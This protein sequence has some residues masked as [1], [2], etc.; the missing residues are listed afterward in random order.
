[1]FSSAEWE[2]LLIF[3]AVERQVSN[4]ELHNAL[5]VSKRYYFF[6]RQIFEKDRADSSVIPNKYA[7][8]LAF[9]AANDTSWLQGL[10]PT[11]LVFVVTS[12]LP[13]RPQRLPDNHQRIRALRSGKSEMTEF[14]ISA[15]L[16]TA[17]FR[18]VPAAVYVDIHI[19]DEVLWFRDK[20][21]GR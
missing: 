15:R 20:S 10:S 8:A 12:R 9:N 6:L 18:R 3:H 11:L 7:L 21:L 1:M 17:L 4:I 16:E 19:G 14:N 13:L 5:R 2:T